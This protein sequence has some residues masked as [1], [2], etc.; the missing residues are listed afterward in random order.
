MQ[1]TNHCFGYYVNDPRRY[2]VVDLI[3]SNA[4]SIEEKPKKQSLIMQ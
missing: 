4:V 1:T 3:L 2:G